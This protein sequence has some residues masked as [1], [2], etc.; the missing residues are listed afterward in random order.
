MAL[1]DKE[2]LYSR[3]TLYIQ[4][5]FNTQDVRKSRLKSAHDFIGYQRIVFY[6]KGRLT[7]NS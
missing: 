5:I 7:H 4:Y 3:S 2:G 1:V 6:A